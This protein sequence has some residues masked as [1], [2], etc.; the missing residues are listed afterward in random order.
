MAEMQRSILSGVEFRSLGVQQLNFHAARFGG[1]SVW[2]VHH[3]LDELME[4]LQTR[5]GIAEAE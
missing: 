3:A 5:I 4:G 2:I 1:S